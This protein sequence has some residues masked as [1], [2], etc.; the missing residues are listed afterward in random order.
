MPVSDYKP[1][2]SILMAV[3][4]G[5]PYLPEAIE[6]I[7]QQTF[8][9]YEFLIIDNGSSDSTPEVIQS[10]GDERVRY[11]RYEPA[12]L[13]GALNYGLKEVTAPLVARM[14]SDDV[15][16]PERV[17]KQVGFM[18]LHAEHVLVGS[19]FDMIAEDGH[20]TGHAVNVV[21]DKVLRWVMLFFNPFLHSG[22][23]FRTDAVIR[24]GSYNEDFAVAQDFDLWRR[25]SLEGK[26]HNIDE[27]LSHKRFTASSTT[28]QSN[29]RQLD[30]AARTVQEYVASYA[31][32]LDVDLL[33]ALRN[34]Y[35]DDH[36]PRLK[37]VSGM[38]ALLDQ[39]T[40]LLKEIAD[41]EASLEGCRLERHVR[42][43]LRFRAH[44]AARR[45]MLRPWEAAKY[46]KVGQEFDPQAGSLFSRTMKWMRRAR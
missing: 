44:C 21:N 30:Y 18:H 26:M 41:A 17:E 13:A 24:C 45:I 40:S 34:W 22:V 33:V 27:V 31:P 14:D 43:M 28:G 5:M 23:M 15:A 38:P 12:G 6:S 16:L 8:T 42:E 20:I 25:L 39:C 10:F 35:I 9:N 36:C 1:A 46:L 32:G 19:A 11:I 2:V 37:A 29:T 3:R 7:L 4:N